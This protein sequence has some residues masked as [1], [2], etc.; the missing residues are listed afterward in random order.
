MLWV[1]NE[2]H[3][4]TEIKREGNMSRRCEREKKIYTYI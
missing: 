3:G 4:T 2:K 1:A